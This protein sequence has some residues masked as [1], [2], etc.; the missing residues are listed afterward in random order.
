MRKESKRELNANTTEMRRYH[1]QSNFNCERA[2][3]FSGGAR[4]YT[5]DRHV[6]LESVETPKAYAIEWE[7]AS[8]LTQNGTILATILRPELER[9]FPVNFFKYE[10]DATVDIEVVSQIATKEF[11]R[12]HYAEMKSA[13]TYLNT[14]ETYPNARR[15]VS[16]GMHVNISMACFGKDSA[17]QE[18]NIMKIH[19]LINRNN[20][21]YTFMCDMLHRERA[22]TQWCGK[23]RADELDRC[24][25]HSYCMNYSHMSEGKASRI[26]IRLVGAQQTFGNWR[27]TMEVIFHLVKKCK[28]LS[29]KDFENPV[30]LWSGCNRYVF[31][32]L[33]TIGNDVKLTDAQLTQI[34]AT[35]SNDEY[36]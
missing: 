34:R 11:W 18:K 14:I 13:Y 17:T 28:E 15:G 19:N 31:N 1:A 22:H 25:S 4:Y 35:M 6:A 29:A 3:D 27:N 10:R 2:N 8:N 7:M 5:S 26:E 21:S 36:I 20:K 24:G 16:C 9:L 23:M 30:K 12:N 32:R 33:S